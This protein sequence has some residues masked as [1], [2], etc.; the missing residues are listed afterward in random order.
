[1]LK[2]VTVAIKEHQKQLVEE[3]M[4]KEEISTGAHGVVH[5][6]LDKKYEELYAIKIIKCKNNNKK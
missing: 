3:F 2:E 6:A 4:I 1:M 5:K